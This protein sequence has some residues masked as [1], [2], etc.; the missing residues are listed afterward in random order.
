MRGRSLAVL[1]AAIVAG[2]S[3]VALAQGGQSPSTQ[4]RQQVET[5]G[6]AAPGAERAL[7]L[8]ELNSPMVDPGLVEPGRVREYL[9]SRGFSDISNLRRDGTFYTGTA[10]WRGQRTDIRVD[11]RNGFIIEPEQHLQK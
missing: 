6:T 11:A 5:T 7:D 9:Q 1:T 4:Q 3:T 10:Q 8:R 2:G